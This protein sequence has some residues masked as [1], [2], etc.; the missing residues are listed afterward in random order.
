[1][2]EGLVT[3][4]SHI[5]KL[6]WVH[7]QCLDR[8][9]RCGGWALQKFPTPKKDSEKNTCVYALYTPIYNFSNQS[10]EVLES[11]RPKLSSVDPKPNLPEVEQENWR[12]MSD[13]LKYMLSFG[14]FFPLSKGG[15]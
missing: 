1:L 6:S 9:F 8:N 3:I 13:S 2:N 7:V 11:A 10:T 4:F 5:S 12:N 15:S 14:R